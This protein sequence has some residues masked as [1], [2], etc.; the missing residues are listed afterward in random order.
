MS[1]M[2][3]VDGKV[4][5][6]GIGQAQLEWLRNHLKTVPKELPSWS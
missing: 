3:K 5:G 4:A 6:S 2:L 1:E